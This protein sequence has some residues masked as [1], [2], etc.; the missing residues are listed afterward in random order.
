MSSVTISE[1]SVSSAWAPS[2]ADGSGAVV[3]GW[4]NEYAPPGT[5]DPEGKVESRMS[6]ATTC[7]GITTTAASPISV[8]AL[9]R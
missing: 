7:I 4:V 9:P 2:C 5:S 6:P 1:M 8:L 3:P